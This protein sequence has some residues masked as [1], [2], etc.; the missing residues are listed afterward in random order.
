[1]NK[2][3][4]KQL[5]ENMKALF[6][7]DDMTLEND[8]AA[9]WYDCLK[10]IDFRR[11]NEGLRLYAQES[12]WI[13]SIAEIRKYANKVPKYTQEEIHK[14]IEEAER[15]EREKLDSFGF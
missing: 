4:F 10:D 11:A 5:Y 6:P 8:A 2:K 9:L 3:E 1:M 12:K 14:F 13:P 7:K 15:K